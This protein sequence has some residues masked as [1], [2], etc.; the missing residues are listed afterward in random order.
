MENLKLDGVTMLNREY[1][2]R[3]YSEEVAES[4]RVL[5]IEK[6][7]RKVAM[8]IIGGAVIMLAGSWAIISAMIIM[9]P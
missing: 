9:L 8:E 7:K 1:N 3:R 5:R 6:A 2:A 4:R